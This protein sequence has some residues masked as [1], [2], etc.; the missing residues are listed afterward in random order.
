[1]SGLRIVVGADDAGVDYKNILRDD[2]AADDRVA[3]VIDVGVNPTDEDPAGHQ[4]SEAYPHIAV[5]AARMVA[6]RRSRPCAAGVRNRTRRG[7]QCQQ[8]ARHPG[9]HRP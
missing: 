3:E 2:L 1:M 6:A 5:R 8:G 9:R 4:N 7:H